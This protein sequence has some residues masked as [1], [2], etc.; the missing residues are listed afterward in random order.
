MWAWTT[1]SASRPARPPARRSCAKACMRS[2]SAL[3]VVI[4]EDTVYTLRRLQ[5]RAGAGDDRHAV[6]GGAA[7]GRRL[8]TRSSIGEPVEG[9]RSAATPNEA[10]AVDSIGI[11]TVHDGPSLAP[12]EII[13]PAVGSDAGDAELPQQLPGSRSVPGG[14]GRR[15]RQYAAADRRHVLHQP[16][17]RHGRADSQDRRADRLRRRGGELLRPRGQRPV[18]APRSATASAS[19]KASAACW[20]RPLGP[21]KYAFNTYAGNIVLVPTTNFV[22]HWVTGKTETHRYDESLR[23]IDLV[24]QR[25]LRAAVAAVGRRAHRLP[26]GAERHPAVRRREEADHADARPDAQ[27]VLPRHRPQED[28]AGAAAR[29]RRDSGTRPARSCGASSAS[30]TSSASTC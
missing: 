20:E 5:T 11:V 28:D 7:R 21:G 1:A 4:T 23:S 22:L 13:A 29:P 3:F 18:R 16:L 10:I 9:G 15:G 25:R 26:A 30:S 6:A 27:R 24:T 19:P 2:T 8:S 14:G 12:G 17:V